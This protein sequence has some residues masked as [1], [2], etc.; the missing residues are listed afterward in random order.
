MM[1]PMMWWMRRLNRSTG[2]KI[3][4]ENPVK[5][6]SIL[7]N[8]SVFSEKKNVRSHSLYVVRQIIF[9]HFNG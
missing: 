6:N 5:G 7:I 9:F 4:Y 2:T 3:Q 8:G 1:W